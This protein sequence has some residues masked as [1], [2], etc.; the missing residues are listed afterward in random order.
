MS[1]MSSVTVDKRESALN[2]EKVA[3]ERSLALLVGQ[4]TISELVTDAHVQIVA[5]ISVVSCSIFYMLEQQV[6]YMY[7]I[8]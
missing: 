8:C 7:F 6:I 5:F 4:V 3:L 1:I 2:M